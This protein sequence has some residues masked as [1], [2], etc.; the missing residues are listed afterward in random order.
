MET[1]IVV[2]LVGFFSQLLGGSLGMGY[3][4]TASSGLVLAGFAPVSSSSVIHV[5]E[6][7]TSIFNGTLHWR[8]QNVNWRVAMQIAIP[9]GVGA[10]CGAVLLSSFNLNAT[11]PWVGAILFM[12][13]AYI[14][15]IFILNSERRENRS[16]NAWWLIPLGGV[17]GFVDSSAGGG[18]G[19]MTT[20]TLV[21][22]GSMGPAQSAGTTSTARFLVALLGT[23]GFCVGLGI[24]G[25]NWL[26]VIGMVVGGLLALPL[27]RLVVRYVSQRALGIV[28]G[29]I[30]V[31]LNIRQMFI[32][33]GM[34]VELTAASMVVA[35][36]ALG[37]VGLLL[38]RLFFR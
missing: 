17:A 31:S 4:V 30:L 21:A 16:T 27:I 23:F 26:A 2:I 12:L 6:V 19:V 1:T 37:L 10:F 18:W 34:S 36:A 9:G 8:A 3:G 32:S 22:T 13:G 35:P 38:K 33:I 14:L 7:F 29:V 24:G 5:V 20:S 11:K 15:W 28:I 25:I